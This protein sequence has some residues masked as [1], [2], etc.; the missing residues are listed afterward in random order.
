MW[1][2]IAVSLTCLMVTA[3]CTTA[4]LAADGLSGTQT[5]A[6]ITRA[7]LAVAINEV[8]GLTGS[9]QNFS[10]LD[11]SDVCYSA[12]QALSAAGIVSG[13]EDGSFRPEN[14]VTRQEAAVM[15]DAAFDLSGGGA[16][17]YTDAGQ[18][19][20]W[21]R[22]AVADLEGT[23]ALSGSPAGTFTPT[24]Y[25]TYGEVDA[26]LAVLAQPEA[27][28][29][30]TTDDIVSIQPYSEL[31]YYA[32]GV[33]RIDITY[34][35]GVDLSGVD[36][37]DY[38]IMDRGYLLPH[39]G[40]LPVSD[41]QVNGQTVTL[42]IDRDTTANRE[43]ALIYEGAN[44]TGSRTK[45]DIYGLNATFSWYRENDGDIV[46]AARAFQYRNNELVIWH[47]GE[48]IED[49]VYQSDI[50]TGEYLADIKCAP[51]N[52]EYFTGARM[53]SFTKDGQTHN[54]TVGGFMTLEELGIQIPSS[55]GIEG[56]Y[57]MA[58]VAF[59]EGYDPDQEYPLIV[60]M[61]GNNA[62]MWDIMENGVIIASN[63]YGPTF[64]NGSAI[65][66][67]GKGVDVIS[68][69]VSHRYYSD[70][71]PCVED[72]TDLTAEGYNYVKDDMALIDYFIDNYGA[73]ANHVVLTGDSR[74]TKSAS[75][76]IM[77]YPGRISTFLCINGNW[78]GWEQWGSGYTQE[79]YMT[80]AENGLS[81]WCIDGELDFD[82]VQV[83]RD[84]RE[85][86]AQ[87]GYTQA[88]IDDMVRIS[89]LATE[90]NYYW[91]ETDHSATKFVYWYLMDTPYYGPGH[92]GA[93]GQIIYE[94][95]SRSMYQLEGKCNEDGSYVTAGFDY[96][97]YTDTLI[98][99]V[100]SPNRELET[101]AR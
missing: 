92:I 69:Y 97:V 26:A 58:Y 48:T 52:I 36:A 22:T 23:G 79:D 47:T 95:P 5:N 60:S 53:D 80:A 65:N 55:S 16:A 61:P 74:G 83:I 51:T 21:A 37:G 35:D 12:V 45:N 62:A 38:Q 41:A 40:Y 32:V 59:P 75:N 96:Q 6:R 78:G 29:G 30:L 33:T 100:M 2:R 11:S 57:V 27:L 91:G 20:S 3:L 64:F 85:L 15:L 66:W 90:Y 34:R 10:D 73:K 87:A 19:A 44:A 24:G 101:V 76:I 7:D 63:P 89:S 70:F 56:D 71:S 17:D 4:A 72:P 77:A 9:G 86:Y 82:N 54:Y 28:S 88:E 84:A 94:D 39:F 67:Y 25:V 13:Y 99:W 43:N 49:A 98:D 93:D 31:S 46:E 68:V 1:K 50:T 8:C 14:F 18:I 42:T 81:I